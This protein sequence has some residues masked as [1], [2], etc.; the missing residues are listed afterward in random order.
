MLQN[1]FSLY[2][3]NPRKCLK[4]SDRSVESK[5]SKNDMPNRE[6]Q[7]GIRYHSIYVRLNTYQGKKGHY[8][9]LSSS[10]Q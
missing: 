9:R 8:L 2:I 1:G 7:K 5:M 6:Q 4:C 3:L 10:T